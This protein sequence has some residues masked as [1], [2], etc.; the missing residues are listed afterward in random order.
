[1][2]PTY[3]GPAEDIKV[4]IDVGSVEDGEAVQHENLRVGF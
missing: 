3:L 1:M 4:E 2:I